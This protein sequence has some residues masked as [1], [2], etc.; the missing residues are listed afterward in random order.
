[1]KKRLNESSESKRMANKPTALIQTRHQLFRWLGWFAMANA[2]IF[3]L[4]GLRYLGGGAMAAS[5]LAWVYL[6]TIYISHHSW[7]AL[8][9]L[10]L[11]LTPVIVLKPSLTWVK[12]L[13]ILL[14]ALM[15]AVIML[16]SLLWSQSRFHIN[17]LTLKILGSSSMIFATVMFLIAIV[18]ETLLA[19]RVW[20]WVISAPAHRG[21]LLGLVIAV[22]FVVAQG[23]Y[24][25][26]D[27]SYY[28]PVTSIAQQLPVQR[29]FTAKKLL[30]RYGLVD[31]SQSRERQLANRMASGKNQSTTANLNYP[32]APLQCTA[33]EPL[34][35]VI[36]M[37]DAMR[38]DLLGS[39]ITP[40]LD[41]LAAQRATRFSNHFS[42]GNSSRMGA[43][44]LFYGLPPGYFGSFEALQKPPVL[45]DRL[46]A[47]NY[48]LG[49]FSSSNLYRPVTLDRTAFA[50]VPNLRIETKPADAPAWERDRIMM[51]DWVSWLDQRATDQPFFGFLFYD[52]VNDMTY[53]PEFAGRVTATA[54]DPLAEE[55]ADYK[56]SMIFVDGLI[57][58]A[59]ADLERRGL[60]EKTVLLITSDHGE[61]FNENGDGVKGHGSGY[62]R[63][64]LGVPMLMVWPGKTPQEIS[65]RTSHYDIAPTLMRRLLGCGNDYSD[66]SSGQ[67]LYDGPQ[68]NWLIAGS[69]YN[70]AVLEPGQITVT[71]PNGTYE[72]R[73][74]NYRLLEKPQING[75]VLEA[76]MRENTRFHK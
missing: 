30:V 12:T 58:E 39:G 24:A 26:A 19:G 75:D 60:S 66:Y 4:I 8:L 16:D 33:A 45:M 52:A 2:V 53:P 40:N 32:L 55:F 47:A 48:Q 37:V 46:M 22:C 43:F 65:H 10:L 27:A 1:M 17:I 74:E 71:F 31:I 23:I 76:V 64:Q 59:I 63:Q 20:S 69:Y 35:L 41:Q 29:G 7:L 49:L 56:T 36:I 61:E 25:W 72:V 50:N 9:P 13:A 70:Y 73:D 6:V 34:N 5:P 18:F 38:G 67:D 42:G 21:R 28:V 54:Q 11:L 51:S 3:A 14:M 57:G 62:S 15:I 44:S 68:W